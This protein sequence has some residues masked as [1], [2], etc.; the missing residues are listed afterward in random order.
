[1]LKSQ[2]LIVTGGGNGNPLQYSCLENPMDRGAWQAI[3]HRVAKSQTWLKWLNMTIIFIELIAILCIP[4]TVFR[5]S[6][7]AS[8]FSIPYSVK[9]LNCLWWLWQNFSHMSFSDQYVLEFSFSHCFQF[10]VYFILFK[11]YLPFILP[12]IC[13]YIMIQTE[14]IAVSKV[15]CGSWHKSTILTF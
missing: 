15:L 11:T 9:P 12:L 1:M 4:S 14:I 6:I 13:N 7:S 10:Q 2:G 8:L 5:W 3:V